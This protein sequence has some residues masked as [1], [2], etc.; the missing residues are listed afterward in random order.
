MKSVKAV[1]TALFRAMGRQFGIVSHDLH[2]DVLVRDLDA[3]LNKVRA[4]HGDAQKNRAA[5]T[6]A[7]VA[8]GDDIKR[9]DDIITKT[10]AVLGQ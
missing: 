7:M 4:V 9:S 1:L 2:G 8:L 6:A 3:A 10:S 5:A